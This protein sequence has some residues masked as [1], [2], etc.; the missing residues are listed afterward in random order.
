M[1]FYLHDFLN[2]PANEALK[3]TI[4]TGK[5]FF[6]VLSYKSIANNY[7]NQLVI[8]SLKY[9]SKNMRSFSNLLNKIMIGINNVKKKN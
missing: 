2:I 6:I 3:T 5:I 8:N 9:C 4:I 1:E 7:A